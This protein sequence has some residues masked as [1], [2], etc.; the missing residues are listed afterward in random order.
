M[1]DVP[2]VNVTRAGRRR[3]D[4]IIDNAIHATD[5]ATVFVAVHAAHDI[6]SNGCH[7]VTTTARAWMKRP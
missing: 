4:Q 7:H 1:G 5:P 2:A 6:Y 3:T